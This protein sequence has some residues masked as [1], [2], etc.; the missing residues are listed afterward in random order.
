MLPRIL[1]TLT[2]DSEY[3]LVCILIW[4]NNQVVH[5]CKNVATND[6]LCI[7]HRRESN[8]HSTMSIINDEAS[9]IRHQQLREK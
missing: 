1:E 6:V 4:I 9:G 8:S 2:D 5:G 7:K 3:R